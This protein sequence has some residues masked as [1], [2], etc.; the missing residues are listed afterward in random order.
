MSKVGG[1]FYKTQRDFGYI[2]Y[3]NFIVTFI[4]IGGNRQS[5]N[6]ELL[7]KLQSIVTNKF[8]IKS[9]S[10]NYNQGKIIKFLYNIDKCIS[11]YRKIIQNKK[12]NKEGVK[13]IYFFLFFKNGP[14]NIQD[15]FIFR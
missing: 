14:S 8:T 3:T 2:C 7:T 5:Y 6:Q 12:I 10:Q 1:F 4:C 11:L 9:Y 13:K 15:S